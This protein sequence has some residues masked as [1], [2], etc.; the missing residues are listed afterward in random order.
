VKSEFDSSEFKNSVIVNSSGTFG[1]QNDGIFAAIQSFKENK[2]VRN[3]EENIL[4]GLIQQ[5]NESD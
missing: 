5:V 2:F 3:H 1:K 4:L